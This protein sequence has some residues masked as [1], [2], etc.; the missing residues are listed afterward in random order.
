[1]GSAR[2]I[3]V[4]LSITLLVLLGWGVLTLG[5]AKAGHTSA[6]RHIAAEAGNT[7]LADQ[8]PGQNATADGPDAP[9]G[10]GHV[11]H[12]LHLLGACAAVLA[13]VLAVPALRRIGEQDGDAAELI[14]RHRSTW[15]TVL[16]PPGLG[17]PA[18]TLLCVLLH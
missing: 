5:F 11:E 13:A 2:W 10:H 7:V 12:A 6:A 17:P 4:A 1:M 16:A 9:P 18:R 14:A 15:S 8:R 3:R